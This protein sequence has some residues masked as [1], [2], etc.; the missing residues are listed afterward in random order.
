MLERFFKILFNSQISK[1]KKYK[2]LYKDESCYIFGDGISI[3]QYDLS[4][5]GNHIGFT[6]A[7]IPF[8]KDFQKLDVKFCSIAE[9]YWFYP[10]E[11]MRK[12]VNGKNFSTFI[13]NPRQA[14][15]KKFLSSN[16]QVTLITNLS[17]IFGLKRSFQTIYTYKKLPD[18]QDKFL[19]NFN[20]L[21]GSF[22][23]LVSIAIYMGF[24]DIYLVG[25]DYLDY[26]PMAH[27]WYEKGRGIKLRDTN[28]EE[29]FIKNAMKAAN[30]ISISPSGKSKYVHSISYTSY[31][32][33]GLHW[34]ENTQICSLEKLKVLSTW[35]HYNIFE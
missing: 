12:Q 25:F 6:A 4:K 9:P 18:N 14:A 26:E 1:I 17:N 3:K 10:L 5:F 7:F 8:H 13:P 11:R 32:G 28:F 23:A 29:E 30:L 16:P 2:N 21:E 33:S 27:H 22:K 31:T 15:F 24:K 35:P 19:K 34:K 20:V